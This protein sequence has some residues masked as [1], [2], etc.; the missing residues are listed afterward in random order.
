MKKVVF[1]LLGATLLTASAVGN[2]AAP[3][4]DARDISAVQ[5]QQTSQQ[6]QIMAELIMQVNQLQQEVRQLRGQVEQQ[7]YRIKQLTQ[8]Q[9]ELYLDL[10]RRL[11]GGAALSTS[12]TEE[13]S[14][15]A[16]DKADTGS[17][18][19]AQ[20]A[21]N[22]AFSLFNEQKYP[23]AKT[24]FKD[25]VRNHA[26][27]PLVSNAH[28]LLGQLHFSDKEYSEA[29]SQFTAVYEQFP[30][31]S[32]KDKAMLKLAQVQEL[33]GDK[34]AAKATYQQ[35]SNLFPNTTAGRLAKAKLDTL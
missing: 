25:F 15:D 28:Y 19:Q 31:T 9:R 5:Q 18:N 30:D 4:V 16:S 2:A 7:D 21:Y 8:Q 13:L 26:K 34:A 35:V 12:E 1:N 10:D 32:I 17:G 24:A 23:Q 6:S 3:V 14:S 27:D 20:Q 29:E 11:Q 22:Q 33:K